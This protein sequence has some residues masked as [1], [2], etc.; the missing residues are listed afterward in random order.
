MLNHCA[1]NRALN[2]ARLRDF[3][4]FTQSQLFLMNQESN[5]EFLDNY[6]LAS[7]FYTDCKLKRNQFLSSQSY[8]EKQL[9]QA[10]T[11]ETSPNKQKKRKLNDDQ[12]DPEDPQLICLL[13]N[14]YKEIKQK[15]TVNDYV[16]TQEKFETVNILAWYELILSMRKFQSGILLCNDL[17]QSK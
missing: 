11:S 17:M 7:Q 6:D 3:D 5:L 16:F 15:W 4:K 10:F 14:A 13:Q 2:F 8:R 9:S 1:K 12:K